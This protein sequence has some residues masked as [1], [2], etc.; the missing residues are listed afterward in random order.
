MSSTQTRGG[1]DRYVRTYTRLVTLR[2]ESE[3]DDIWT[4]RNEEEIMNSRASED[5]D[6]DT[7][8]VAPGPVTTN[9]DSVRGLFDQIPEGVVSPRYP[10]PGVIYVDLDEDLDIFEI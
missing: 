5:S 9:Q 10:G 4:I 2:S 6:M 1:A 7:D 8:I 3:Y